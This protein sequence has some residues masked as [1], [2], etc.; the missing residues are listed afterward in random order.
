MPNEWKLTNIHKPSGNISGSSDYTMSIEPT[1]AS[2]FSCFSQ[3]CRNRFVCRKESHSFGRLMTES[4]T[5]IRDV[6]VSEFSHAKLACHLT[7]EQI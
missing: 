7:F 5:R 3:S 2:R 4:Q 6:A 1:V